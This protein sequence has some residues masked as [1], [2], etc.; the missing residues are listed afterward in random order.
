MIKLDYQT[1]NPRWGWSGMEFSDWNSFS[2]TL[3]FLSNIQHFK[4]YGIG[5]SLWHNSISVHIE[6]NDKQG[7][8]NKEGRIHYYKDCSDL[9]ARLC[10]LNAHSSAGN[11]A[12]TCRI[13]SNGYILSLINDFGFT[14]MPRFGYLTAD[15]LPPDNAIIAVNGILKDA[16]ANQELSQQE[17]QNCLAQFDAGFHM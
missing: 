12:I 6:R 13:N 5:I 1:D 14:A 2:L 8:W 16:L 4:G 3:G 15:I 11:T 10:D 9:A 7:A 17:I